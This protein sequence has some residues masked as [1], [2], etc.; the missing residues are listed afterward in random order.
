MKSGIN[1]PA[2][3]RYAGEYSVYRS[4]ENRDVLLVDR[5]EIRQGYN[6]LRWAAVLDDD[7]RRTI[8]AAYNMAAFEGATHPKI[9]TSTLRQYAA[10]LAGRGIENGEHEAAWTAELQATLQ[11]RIFIEAGGSEPIEWALSNGL[12]V[13]APYLAQIEEMM[14]VIARAQEPSL[15]KGSILDEL[16]TLRYGAWCLGLPDNGCPSRLIHD[17]LIDLQNRFALLQEVVIAGPEDE[18]AIVLDESPATP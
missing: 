13:P 12:E 11:H 16:D 2:R 8:L 3:P 15:P 7:V 6:T 14:A 4:P 5:A 17:R 1:S 9:R 10:N 18:R